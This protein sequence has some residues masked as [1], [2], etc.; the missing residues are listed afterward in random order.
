MEGIL[1]ALK[2]TKVFLNIPTGPKKINRRKDV[3]TNAA[4]AINFE[5][6]LVH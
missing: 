1:H 2:I 3:E 4:T 5:I 6:L